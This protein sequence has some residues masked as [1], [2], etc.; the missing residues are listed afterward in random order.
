MTA[1]SRPER[2]RMPTNPDTGS[3]IEIEDDFTVTWPMRMPPPRRDN[4]ER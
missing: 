1:T 4:D 3:D 2:T